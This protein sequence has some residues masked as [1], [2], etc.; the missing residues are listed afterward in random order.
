L[1]HALDP[2][3]NTNLNDHPVLGAINPTAEHVA[4]FIAEQLRS[5]LPLHAQLVRVTV[6]EAPG[7]WAS[8]LPDR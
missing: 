3:R 4:R 7:C 8:F 5:E 1:D 2:L 6:G